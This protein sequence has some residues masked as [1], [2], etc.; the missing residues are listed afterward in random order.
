MKTPQKRR[1]GGVETSISLPTGEGENIIIEGKEER[2]KGG[3]A[4]SRVHTSWE[5]G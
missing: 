3:E 1:V 5:G 4:T 2:R